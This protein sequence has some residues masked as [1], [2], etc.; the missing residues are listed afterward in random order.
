MVGDER[1]LLVNLYDE[2]SGQ[3]GNALSAS[4]F[5]EWTP[6]FCSMVVQ[7]PDNRIRLKIDRNQTIYY[8]SPI[9]FWIDGYQITDAQRGRT[10][11]PAGLP[12]SGEILRH[13]VTFGP[14]W[15]DL[16]CFNPEFNSVEPDDRLR[17]IKAWVQD[18]DNYV[19]FAFDSKDRMFKL[20]QILRRVP[21]ILC[22]AGPIEFQP[23]WVNRIGV[24]SAPNACDFRVRIGTA[25]NYSASGPPLAIKPTELWIGS[26]PA[27][28][29]QAP[30]LYALSRTFS[31]ALGEQEL[32][33]ELAFL[34]DTGDYDF[35]GDVDRFDFSSFPDCLQ[36]P[37]HEGHRPSCQALDSDN[38]GDV[39]LIDVGAF[40]SVYTGPT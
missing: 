27:G 34:G 31:V 5:D 17:T 24:R 3:A 35:D 16:L 39:D 12:R 15:T 32:A 38:D 18:S 22:Q 9:T 14:E 8:P 23:G 2:N 40:Q 37:E 6:A 25:V 11:V 36:G 28:A 10:F 4:P 19:Q 1:T 7:A 29:D 33:R 13:E 30:G 26:S 20:I 21:Q